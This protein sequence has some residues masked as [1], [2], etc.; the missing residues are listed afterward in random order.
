[1]RYI[2]HPVMTAG[3]SGDTLTYTTK[4]INF[5]AHP[6]MRKPWQ[7]P[8]VIVAQSEQTDAKPPHYT[9]THFGSTMVGPS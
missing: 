5:D 7:T 1:M 4:I 9:E 2:R 8:T 3:P 6:L